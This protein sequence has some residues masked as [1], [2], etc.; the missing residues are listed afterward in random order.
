MQKFPSRD[1]KIAIFYTS[2]NFM[3]NVYIFI[4]ALPKQEA[5]LS[6][7]QPTVLVVSDLQGH[8]RSIISI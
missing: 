7:G 2:Q 3:P 1:F 6:L 8:P 5:Q 4:T